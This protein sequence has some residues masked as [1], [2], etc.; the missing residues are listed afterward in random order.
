MFRLF[1]AWVTRIKHSK[2]GKT[3]NSMGYVEVFKGF[4]KTI[5]P[6]IMPI[7]TIELWSKITPFYEITKSNLLQT[8]KK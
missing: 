7:H 3:P 1:P 8:Y 6:N 2:N 5:E 4:F